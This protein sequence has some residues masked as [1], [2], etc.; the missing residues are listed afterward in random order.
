[1]FEWHKKSK[2]AEQL[3]FFGA[4]KQGFISVYAKK[5]RIRVKAKV[6]RP[7]GDVLRDIS[8]KQGRE[9]L[10]L[11]RIEQARQL[12]LGGMQGLQGSQLYGLCDMAAANIGMAQAQDYA[13]HDAIMSNMQAMAAAR[14]F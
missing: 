1:M 4:K 2:L 14:L 8:L 11:M 13:R 9:Q 12:G 6:D 7:L 10:D 5:P 3:K